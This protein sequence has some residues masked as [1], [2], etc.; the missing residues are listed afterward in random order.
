MAPAPGAGRQGRGWE[1][2]ALAGLVGAAA[3][4]RWVAWQRTAVLFDDGPRFLAI[5][6]AL[7]AGWGSAALRDSFHPLYPALAAGLHRALGAPDTA[8]AWE[9]A[10]AT[11]SVA[12]GAA[13]VGFLFLFLRDAFGRGPAWAGAIL[14]AVHARAVEYSSDVQSEGLYLAC[15]A[16][17]LW[18]G[19]RAWRTGGPAWAAGA[20]LA[21]GLAY[22]ARPEGLGLAV[23]VGGLGLGSIVRQRWGLGAGAAWLGALGAAAL[24]CV[25]PYVWALHEVT[26]A[27]TLTN[28]K[29]VAALVSAEA[30]ATPGAPVAPPAAA[31]RP[32]A[33]RPAAAA[34]A[35]A[36]PPWLDALGLQAPPAVAPAEMA[37]EYLE[38]DGLRVA[39][40]ESRATRVWEALRM[41][42]RHARGALRHGVLAL[43]LVGLWASRGRPGP[44]AVYALAVLALY[45]AALYALTLSAG[46][47]SRRHGLPPL[48]PLFGYAGAGAL[49]AGAWAAGVARAPARRALAGALVLA[50]F[51]VADLAGQRAPKRAD[52]LAERRAAEWLREHA[53]APGRVAASRQRLGYYAELPFVP[54]AGVADHALGRYLSR[55]DARYV[56]VDEPEQLAALR[57][58]EGEAMRV[59]HEV[60][61]A[62]GRAWVVERVP[63]EER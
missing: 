19:W 31:P 18:A 36:P 52:Q 55:V 41:L 14:L 20:G 15:F 61:A 29:S 62:G 43:V 35:P 17:G 30:V 27:W 24:L 28:K 45:L 16:A 22:L 33:G 60:E 26:G 12:A 57:R 58:A 25:A 39:L 5:A 48:L 4:L 11:V 63:R 37:A 7:D 40:A 51:A 10:A 59:L 3:W 47:V 32:A 54:L 49:A 50:A 44:R 6:R 56:L 1:A 8:A 42:V 9:D 34:P 38:Q 2:V 46:Y 13:A 23:V 21:S 53:P